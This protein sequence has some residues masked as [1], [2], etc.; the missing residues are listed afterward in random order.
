MAINTSELFNATRGFDYTLIGLNTVSTGLLGYFLLM[1]LFIIT[2]V[3]LRNSSVVDRL[4]AAGVV[5]F[6]TS[7]V[8]WSTGFSG[9]NVVVVS[10]SIFVVAVLFSFVKN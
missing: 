3:L 6:I 10:F 9:F 5:I 2:I 8:F 4:L 7:L 1:A